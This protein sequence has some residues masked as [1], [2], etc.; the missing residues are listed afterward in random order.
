MGA[1]LNH[2]SL[3]VLREQKRLNISEVAQ[4]ASISPPRLES[5]EKGERRPTRL[6]LERL[7]LLY[8]VPIYALFS[9][10]I[11]N[12]PETPLDFRKREP[13][14]AQLSPKGIKALW[15]SEKIARFSKQLAVALEF[16]PAKFNS[17]AKSAANP[18]TRATA[19][20]SSFDEWFAT[21]SARLDLTGTAEQ[22]TT[23]ALRLFFEVQAGVVN[24]NDAPP[25]DYMGFYME[26]D[27]GHEVIF[28]NRSIASKKAQLFTL[29]HEYSHLLLRQQ[30]I[31]NPFILRNAIERQC[32]AFAAEFL[33]P[34]SEFKQT[35][36]S[37][38]RSVR[39]D[40]FQFVAAVSN[41]ILLSKH[42]TAIR[43]KEAGYISEQDLAVFEAA[44][45]QYPAQ[46][47]ADDD[48]DAGTMNAP[49]A[50]R[51]SEL[52]YLPVYLAAVGCREGM[53]DGLDVQAG[54]GLSETLQDR[55]FR[56]ATKRIEAALP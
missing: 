2:R 24:I 21:R 32:N 54:I 39:S 4:F 36:E 9:E 31:S 25:S 44:W 14:P 55:A 22:Q 16:E 6:Q 46:E 20:R 17:V 10:G 35:V 37:L 19:L 3:R 13:E 48:Y 43:L 23:A 29:A 49:H 38:G 45:S 33:A 26:P 42:A 27:G 50:K 47:K 1:M 41:R 40:I 56:L 15:S 12:S 11:P 18:A 53:I 51:I 7:A 34:M 8:G 52:G 5:V 30:G 28:V